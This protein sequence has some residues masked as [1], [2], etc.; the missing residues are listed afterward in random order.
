MNVKDMAAALRKYA[1][2]ARADKGDRTIKE[3]P[4]WKQ[5]WKHRG[6]GNFNKQN[7]VYMAEG[8]DQEEGDQGTPHRH[9]VAK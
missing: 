5:S 2:L 1:D 9:R 7:G 6:G 3:P 8:S 4:T